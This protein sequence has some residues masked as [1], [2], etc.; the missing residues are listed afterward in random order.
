MCYRQR[1]R[2]IELKAD[3]VDM[4]AARQ[5]EVHDCGTFSSQAVDYPDKG[6]GRE[7]PDLNC[8]GI[9]IQWTGIDRYCCQQDTG[10]KGRGL[11]DPEMARLAVSTMMPISLYRGA[12]V[13]KRNRSKS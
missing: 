4:L 13:G 2:G 1:P 8:P 7:S 5:V 9:L 12:P 6:V 10:N 3:L 11:P